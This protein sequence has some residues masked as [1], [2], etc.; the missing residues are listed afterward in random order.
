MSYLILSRKWRPQAFKD[1]AGQEHISNTLINAI[2]SNKI[3]G[4]YLFCGP[5]GTGKTST[6]RILAKAINC[7]S[8]DKPTPNPCGKCQNC[9]EI[10]QGNS[11]D[12]I[13]IDGASNRGIDDIRQLRENINYAPNNSRKKIY[14]IDEV[15]M[16]TTP[17]FNALLKTLEEPPAHVNF[18]FATT[19][20]QKLPATI[21]SRC[22]RFYF[23]RIPTDVIKAKLTEICKEEGI[24]IEA[25]AIDLLSIRAE[26]GLR[27]AESML[28][29]VASSTTQK[30]TVDVAVSVLGI[31]RGESLEHLI[32][33]ILEH[34]LNSAMQELFLLR[35]E[36]IAPS[37]IAHS[38]MEV[39]H[40]LMAAKIGAKHDYLS[41]NIAE[42]HKHINMSFLLR[43]ARLLGFCI[44]QIAHSPEPQLLLESTIAQ[45]VYF[46][47]GVDIQELVDYLHKSKGIEEHLNLQEEHIPRQTH[48]Q[49][50]VK[51]PIV[52]KQKQASVQKPVD[53]TKP[54]KTQE[55]KKEAEVKEEVV[56]RK[57]LGKEDKAKAWSDFLVSIKNE[58]RLYPALSH[59]HLV[60][61]DGYELQIDISDFFDKP[62]LMTEGKLRL[63]ELFA[64]FIGSR[65]E[66]IFTE[67][68]IM[69]KLSMQNKEK[70]KEILASDDKL[71]RV[72][73][74][75][76]SKNMEIE[77]DYESK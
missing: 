67:E 18:I 69:E 20:P 16:L 53:E 2:E 32:L 5:R 12:V 33:A 59:S 36:G 10:T 49:E 44:N 72:L 23:K 64:K 31:M 60:P 14:I 27:D 4:A 25:D 1:L 74:E 62:W 17:A 51:Q 37:S 30:I 11:F 34:D 55:L 13:E 9:K 38:L 71:E 43:I 68:G 45:I 7:L 42:M 63:E 19:E 40:S 65:Y 35:E 58:K 24:E 28:D 15:H 56:V 76:K 41:S 57:V 77:L 75:F 52:P 47:D 46:D 70:Q 3:A 22:Q 6:A 29:Q 21:I 48:V 73:K 54:I 39:V 66:I 26:G 50:H 8:S 61:T